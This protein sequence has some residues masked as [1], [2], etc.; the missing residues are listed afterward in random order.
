MCTVSEVYLASASSSLNS[1]HSL[2]VHSLT[3]VNTLSLL[4]YGSYL[5]GLAAAILNFSLCRCGS[6]PLSKNNVGSGIWG[7]GY[8]MVTSVAQL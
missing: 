4:Y 2:P 6:K 8:L 1:I 7:C 5:L 3:I